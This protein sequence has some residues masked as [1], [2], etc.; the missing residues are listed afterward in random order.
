MRKGLSTE[1]LKG[2][3]GHIAKRYDFQHSLIT[4]NADQRGRR[5]LVENTVNE[6][7]EVLDSGSGTGTT[8]IMAAKKVGQSG[9]ATLFDL[10]EDMLSV[11]QEKVVRENLQERVAFQTGDMVN[12]PF[13]DNSFDVVLSTYSLCPLYDPV[14]GALELYRV[15][16]PGG[17]LGVGHSTEPKNAIVKYLADRVEDIA[18]RFPWLSMGC[19]S[20]NVLPA[21]E[22]AGGKVL[23]SKHIGV[24]LWP[25]LVFVIKKPLT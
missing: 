4:F 6:G 22:N 24:P 20:V 18:W 25:F 12:L 7:D 19:R 9:K 13:D 21:L 1:E 23:L 10:S 16:K 17:K 2:I 3:Y 5:I 8:G 11:A 14:K 15:T